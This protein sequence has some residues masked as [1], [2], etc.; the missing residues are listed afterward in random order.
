M[1][2]LGAGEAAEA[3]EG[4]RTVGMSMFAQVINAKPLDGYRVHLHFKDGTQGVVDIAKLAPFRG[5]FRPLKDPKYFRR[6]KVDREA[7]TICWPNG[8]DID[9]D[10]LYS[11]AT[12]SPLPEV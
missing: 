5:V 6:L 4:G 2:E 7:G 1:E 8:A 3:I 10:V 9:P 11:T 12:G